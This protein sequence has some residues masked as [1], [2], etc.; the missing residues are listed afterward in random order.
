MIRRLKPFT[1]DLHQTCRKH[2]YPTLS[3]EQKQRLAGL[4]I[5]ALHRVG[6][7]I[8]Q[9]MQPDDDDEWLVIMR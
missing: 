7:A 5:F 2:A 6:N 3:T 9:R 8:E 4:A 1:I